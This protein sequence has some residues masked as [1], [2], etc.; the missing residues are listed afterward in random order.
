MKLEYT[1]NLTGYTGVLYGKSSFLVRDKEGNEIFH[2]GFRTFDSYDEL[3]DAV[4]YF[5]DPA[6]L[7]E[8][9][10]T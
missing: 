3:K 9:I 8:K 5:V 2:T 1:N 7:I 4:D 6:I 10:I